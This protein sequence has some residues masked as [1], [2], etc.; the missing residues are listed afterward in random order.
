ME[1]YDE[2]ILEAQR[3]MERR[4]YTTLETGI[5]VDDSLETFSMHT[6]P[7]TRIHVYLPDSFVI[8]PERVRA[9]KYP[10]RDSPDYIYTSLSGTVNLGFNLLPEVLKEGDTQVMSSQSQK[11]AKAAGRA[12]DVSAEDFNDEV[13]DDAPAAEKPAKKSRK[14]ASRSDDPVDEPE[15]GNFDGPEPFE[16]PVPF[17]EPLPEDGYYEEGEA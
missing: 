10:Y 15:A 8:L 2:Q 3:E 11:A 7:D 4:N 17:D 12:V 1:G 14:K 13:E 5:Y 6:L 9:V 16:E